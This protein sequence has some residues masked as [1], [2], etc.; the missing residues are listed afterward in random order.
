MT[1]LTIWTNHG[2]T[3]EQEQRLTAACKGHELIH[4]AA[5][6]PG[7]LGRADIAFGQPPLAEVTASSALRWVQLSSAGYGNYDTEP[8]RSAFAKRKAVLTKSS[9]VYA[10]PCAEHLLAFMLA[11]GLYMSRHIKP[12]P[13]SVAPAPEQQP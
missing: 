10:S 3:A 2:L 8:L 4:G 6:S 11:Q 12:E 7:E 5:A 9:F 1:R 13:G